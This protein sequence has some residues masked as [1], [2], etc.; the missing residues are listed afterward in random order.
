MTDLAAAVII[1]DST[2]PADDLEVEVPRSDGTEVDNGGND[3]V[4]TA[5]DDGGMAAF[6]LPTTLLNDSLFHEPADD[7]GDFLAA[8]DPAGDLE[9]ADVSFV[10]VP[11]VPDTAA[12]PEPVTSTLVGLG[13][14]GLAISLRRRR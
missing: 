14:F 6:T 2:E 10:D 1:H 11:T 8:G 13:A 9:F 4:Q 12:T 5:H 3:T 7:E